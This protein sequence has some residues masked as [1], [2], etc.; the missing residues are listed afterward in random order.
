MNPLADKTHSEVEG[1][2]EGIFIGDVK[3]ICG[4]FHQGNAIFS[5]DSVGRQCVANSLKA[6]I[7][8]RCQTP[9]CWTQEDID[10]ILIEGDSLYRV[11]VDY[12]RKEY[13]LP[14]DIPQ[15][16][17]HQ[18]NLWKVMIGDD[19]FGQIFHATDISLTLS[20]VFNIAVT[21]PVYTNWLLCFATGTS[22]QGST[23]SIMSFDTFL[24]TFDAHSRS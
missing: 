1:T 13:L 20:D 24:V 2:I 8:A 3:T 16:V 12:K 10:N 11:I 17:S 21:D 22:G 15:Y 14:T 18:N 5:P 23:I 4:H 9:T 7:H 6:I 19:F